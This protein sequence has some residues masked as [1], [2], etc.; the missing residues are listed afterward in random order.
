MRK[1]IKVQVNSYEHISVVLVVYSNYN[2]VR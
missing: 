2:K 1:A